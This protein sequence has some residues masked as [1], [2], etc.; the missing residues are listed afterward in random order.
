M[1]ERQRKRLGLSTAQGLLTLSRGLYLE[2]RNNLIQFLLP[3]FG[4]FRLLGIMLSYAEN[5]IKFLLASRT[6][7]LI[8][9]HLLSLLSLCLFSFQDELEPISKIA[10]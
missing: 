1:V 5:D 6:S 8:G 3:A 10:N 9:R 4:A 2:G 7:I